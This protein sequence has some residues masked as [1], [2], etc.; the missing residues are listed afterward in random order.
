MLTC[1]G[2]SRVGDLTHSAVNPCVKRASP[3][4]KKRHALAQEGPGR[5][6]EPF[7]P[8]S[9]LQRPLRGGSSCLEQRVTESQQLPPQVIGSVPHHPTVAPLAERHLLVRTAAPPQGAQGRVV[10]N[11]ETLETS[12]RSD[13]GLARYTKVHNNMQGHSSSKK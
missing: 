4:E 3:E 12:L 6:P 11:S 2:Q 8:P 9:V 13:W 5:C 10:Y 1:A 7:I